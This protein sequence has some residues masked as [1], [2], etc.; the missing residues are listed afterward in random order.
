VALLAA[1]SQ[2]AYHYV[3]YPN[4]TTFTPI[5]EK[6]NLA[7]LPN[8]TVTFFVADQSPNQYPNNEFGSILGQIRQA[9]Q[10]WNSV[11]VSDLR[12]AFGGLESYSA[13]PTAA[14]PGTAALNAATPGGDVIFVDTPGVLG[15]GAPT[16]STTAV[17]GPGGTFY[18]I[19]RGLVMI[20]RDTASQP[21]P[22]SSETFFTT[23]VHEMGHA[24]G[25]QHTW[26]GSAMSQGVIRT[27]SRARPLD[28]DDI[29]ALATLYGKNNWQ[30][31]YG[32]I[33]GRVTF[34]NNGNSVSMASVVAISATGPAVSTLTHPD[35]TYRIDGIPANL[36][37][38]VYVHP[39]PPD[40]I[41]ADDSGLRRPTDASNNPFNASGPFQTIFYAGGSG[42]LDPRN[43]TPITVTAGS[44][45]GDINFSVQPRPAVPTY[46]VQTYSRITAATR[47]YGY[48]G[49][50]DV[51]GYPGFVNSTSTTGLVTARAQA[52]AVLPTPQSVTILGN[53]TPA[54]LN[55]PTAPGVYPFSNRPGDYMAIFFVVP[56]GSGTGPR[57]MVFN[58]GND[59]YVLP[60]GVD[61]VQKGP[62]VAASATANADGTVTVAGA[63]FGTD[64]RVFFD[65][66]QASPVSFNG[67]DQQGSLTVTPPTGAS[68]QVASVTVYNSDGQN[69]TIL[70]SAPVP[71]Y[72]YPASGSPQ[73]AS[74]SPNALPAGSTGLVE[75]T[76]SGMTLVD[77]QVTIGFGSGD[78]QVRRVFVLGPTRAIANVAITA[79]AT[80]GLSQVSVVSGM[81]VASAQNAFQTQAPRSGLPVIT[82]VVNTDT[83]SAS[84]QAGQSVTI[85]GQ[86]L[87]G[88]QISLNDTAVTS[89]SSS[90][91]QT[92][93]QIPAGQAAGPVVLRLTGTA[94]AA[95]PVMLRVDGPPPVITA[96]NTGGASLAASTASTAAGAGDLLQIVVNGLDP[97]IASNPQGRI[98]V[99]ISGNE[100]PVGPITAISANV[101][102]IQITLNQSFGASQVPVVVW[103]DGSASAPVNVTIR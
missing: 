2:A 11:A 85:L 78:V 37:Y 21:W 66:L 4:R 28:P 26:T 75:I 73:V 43:A 22:S 30:A 76:V 6:F 63:G 62:P 82:S 32:S 83:G 3:H 94:G 67:T 1:T 59:I 95:F 97:A 65:G 41:A 38:S 34:A 74:V 86:N 10:A 69:S 31:E 57:H 42:T 91:T 89:T 12:V 92:T 54:T 8:N 81:Q 15:M 90:A 35:G 72:T 23:A 19:V 53:F 40:A 44:S 33:S 80:T 20:S 68:G 70:S 16:I 99:T 47:Q 49:D 50:T 61:L 103:V 39:L 77:G 88:A 45:A 13:S 87:T 36:N 100:M 25:L 96:V 51:I 55:S 58:F 60:S 48:P 64:S 29:A 52:P 18:P 17:Q 79:N 14:N 98:R 27:T 101:H 71:T 56:P 9:A 24:I 93:F 5:Y 102:Q 46:N 7:S 84:L